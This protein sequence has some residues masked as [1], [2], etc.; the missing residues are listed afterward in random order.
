[1]WRISK[2]LNFND[3]PL[4]EMQLLK[5]FPKAQ[6]VY[7]LFNC[8]I[9]YSKDYPLE[10]YYII[11]KNYFNKKN[12]NIKPNQELIRKTVYSG[13]IYNKIK[14][15]KKTIPNYKEEV[16]KLLYNGKT[17][18][19]GNFFDK[20]PFDVFL[21]AEKITKDVVLNFTVTFG[22]QII[23]KRRKAKNRN[24]E[25]FNPLY[26][27]ESEE[28]IINM[29]KYM[30]TTGNENLDFDKI[31]NDDLTK[32]PYIERSLNLDYAITSLSNQNILNWILNDDNN[33]VISNLYNVY[34]KTIDSNNFL[35]LVI[36]I[37]IRNNPNIGLILNSQER[38]N[39]FKSIIEIIFTNYSFPNNFGIYVASNS[40]EIS[41]TLIEDLSSDIIN[42]LYELYLTIDNFIDNSDNSIIDLV[43]QELLILNIKEAGVTEEVSVDR[44][45]FYQS[46]SEIFN[47]YKKTTELV[48]DITINDDLSDNFI[49]EQLISAHSLVLPNVMNI[50]VESYK[51][52]ENDLKKLILNYDIVMKYS[53]N[54]AKEQYDSLS[55]CA[56]FFIN[57]YSS[58]NSDDFLN[59]FLYNTINYN[60]GFINNGLIIPY[61][62]NEIKD[63]YFRY[64]IY[65]VS[66][67]KQDL[68]SMFRMGDTLIYG[69]ER[70]ICLEIDDQTYN[71]LFITNKVDK[72][73]IYK[74]SKAANEAIY[75]IVKVYYDTFIANCQD[76][77]TELNNATTGNIL[78]NYL[79]YDFIK[80]NTLMSF[81]LPTIRMYVNS[82]FK[83]INNI[84][85]TIFKNHDDGYISAASNL[86]KKMG[87]YMLD[88]TLLYENLYNKDEE[89]DTFELKD[90]VLPKSKMLEIKEINNK[91]LNWGDSIIDMD[92]S[93][94]FMYQYYSLLYYIEDQ[95]EDVKRNFRLD[96]TI[97]I[98]KEISINIIQKCQYYGNY[99]LLKNILDRYENLVSIITEY[100]YQYGL[101]SIDTSNYVP[102]DMIANEYDKLVNA[103]DY[104]INKMESNIDTSYYS[105]L[106]NF[107]SEIMENYTSEII[108]FSN[109]IKNLF[110]TEE[111][112]EETEENL[113]NEHKLI[114]RNKLNSINKNSLYKRFETMMTAVGVFTALGALENLAKNL[115]IYF[116]S[117]DK[118][119]EEKQAIE[120]KFNT[121][122][123]NISAV[124]SLIM[125]MFKIPFGDAFGQ[126]DNTTATGSDLM[127]AFLNMVIKNRRTNGNSSSSSSQAESNSSTNSP[128]AEIRL[129]SYKIEDLDITV[130]DGQYYLSYDNSG[131]TKKIKI[132][133][134]SL[135]HAIIQGNINT[136]SIQVNSPEQSNQDQNKPDQNKPDQNNQD[137]NNQDQNNQNQN[138][139]NQ[140][141]QDQ[142]NQNQNNQ[143]Q[144]NQDQNNQ[145]QNNQNSNSNLS[146]ISDIHV[147]ENGDTILSFDEN[148][149][150]C[151]S[152]DLSN[153]SKRAVGKS[154]CNKKQILRDSVFTN[155]KVKNTI[156]NNI[157]K[158]D[159][160]D[161]DNGY[162]ELMDSV[163][164][165][166]YLSEA[167]DNADDFS[168]NS[169]FGED[170]DSPISLEDISNRMKKSANTLKNNVE[171]AVS[172]DMLSTSRKRTIR[173][174]TKQKGNN[175]GK[176]I[177]KVV[178]ASS[179]KEKTD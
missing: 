66:L 70:N 80:D 28:E 173:H 14:S 172:Q 34:G 155:E 97:L 175:S 57:T 73:C 127:E 72:N 5:L 163:E 116:Q 174:S 154:N 60:E 13:S 87:L 36:E 164:Y 89:I 81:H 110:N 122:F 108:N 150:T 20:D 62:I 15:L 16:T 30:L 99:F 65:A 100:I 92:Y 69:Y 143:D 67:I 101:S 102:D 130:E 12:N 148:V 137:Q 68:N 178:N 179:K 157:G 6:M 104:Y 105:L 176:S 170:A 142:N 103:Y 31:L 8:N 106:G 38:F 40:T 124:Q 7:L 120:E 113:I 132:K 44:N 9:V 1:M 27:E 53:K 56:N 139:Q 149:N 121:I 93:N 118:T 141:N 153:N 2:Y 64:I 114:K 144:N 95:E 21:E 49:A 19:F 3:T 18:D 167:I 41:N 129:D 39:K 84:F 11:N 74:G 76:D 77:F 119:E 134:N 82:N 117:Q 52:D 96:R 158:L 25:M 126:A 135:L 152:K 45:Q 112:N 71:S 59:R 156:K 140:N 168:E 29:Y 4:G 24:F 85:N 51:E 17:V 79:H 128:F 32:N 177:S 171:T 136:E 86:I 147:N 169:Q 55:Y 63:D 33:S 10:Q 98:I 131:V 160:I 133:K 159:D 109:E 58:L 115:M 83:E 165:S 161:P 22:E 35:N 43:L 125:I 111:I 146:P 162:K 78:S 50:I 47:I 23:T 138:N 75:K 54:M 123:R 88:T 26:Q 61:H 107:T 151:T 94:Y 91:I 42:D 37:L 166:N 90:I 46:V 145:D 48:E